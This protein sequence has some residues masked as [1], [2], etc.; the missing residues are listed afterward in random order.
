[1]LQMMLMLN[2]FMVN[3]KNADFLLFIF[4]CWISTSTGSFKA[5]LWRGYFWI[6]ECYFFLLLGYFLN[7]YCALK[8]DHLFLVVSF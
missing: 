2:T 8:I 7:A 5:V 6:A 1:M 4:G 3:Y